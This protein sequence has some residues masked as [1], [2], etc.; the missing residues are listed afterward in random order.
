MNELFMF[1]II[2]LNSLSFLFSVIA[3]VMLMNSSALCQHV[4]DSTSRTI[5][6][7]KNGEEYRGQIITMDSSRIVL[8]TTNGEM[9][10]VKAN[11]KSI[12]TSDYHGLYAFENPKRSSY[13]LGPTAIPLGK[14]NGNYQNISLFLNFFNYG[15]TNNID[16]GV[17]FLFPFFG[18]RPTWYFS[19]KITFDI[20][21]TLHIGG[22]VFGL[23]FFDEASASFCYGVATLGNSDA[24]ISFT[25][26]WGFVDNEFSSQ[27]MVIISGIQRVGKSMALFTENFIIP[28]GSGSTIYFGIHGFRIMSS[29]S[30]W[31]FGFTI[32]PDDEQDFLVFPL[33]SFLRAF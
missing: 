5:I 30:A 3:L 13:L 32:F 28:D 8:Q 10:L 17:G 19:P 6:R 21:R 26:G 16:L 23:Q 11:I 9:N 20:D 14:K 25:T 1:R 27:P 2:K 22:G 12:R 24:N 4:S 33:I 15:L 31:D 7:M 29:K 18:D